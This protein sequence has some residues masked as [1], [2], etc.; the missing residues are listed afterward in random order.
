M[1]EDNSTRVRRLLK[2]FH[3][4]TNGKRKIASPKDSQ[5]FVEALPHYKLPSRCV[6]VLLS[7]PSGM[8][9]VRSAV[10][11]DISPSF[12]T[13]TSLKLAEFLSDPEIKSVADGQFLRELVVAIIQPPTFWNAA[14][15]MFQ[16]SQ[17]QRAPFDPLLG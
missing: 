13:S 3:D 16:N 4:V 8:D 2:L 7:S 1:D 12:I 15:K 10:R 11:V 14:V 17:F 6:E 9:A 5:L